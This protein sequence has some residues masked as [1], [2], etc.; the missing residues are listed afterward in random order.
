MENF[1]RDWQN[2]SDKNIKTVTKE[3]V[4]V[5]ISSMTGV[6][7][8]QLDDGESKRLLDMENI[9]HREV[10]G[11]DEAV[12]L[13]SGAV[14]RSRAGVSS[15]K[16][17]MGS[18]IFL[19]PTGV[20][21]TQLAKALAKFL[22]G[23]EDSLVRVDMS[24]Y[25][26]KQNASRLVGAPP[27]YIGYEEGGVLTEAVRQHPYSVVLL[28]EIEKAHPDIF[29]LLLQL[30]EEGELSDNLGHTVSFKNTVI[31]MTSNAGARQITTGSR[32]GFSHEEDGIM[33]YEDIKT[34]AMEELKKIMAP[35][36]LNRIDD[37]VVFNALNREQVSA[38][39]DIQMK[40]LDNRLAEQ[41]L[42]ISLK[43]EARD[44]MIE[45]GYDPSMGA[46]PMRRLIQRDIEDCLATLLL[47]GKRGS[48][49]K[50]VVDV[51]DGKLSVKFKKSRSS[52]EA[53]KEKL[54]LPSK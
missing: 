35:E 38:I 17:P 39:L 48:S 34:N 19:G 28:D 54:L 30:L 15:L 3:D 18:F 6:P 52:I 49:D 11:Q 31:I 12:S 27:G 47:S 26:E 51:C 22:F 9:I 16:R 50:I 40:E 7:L 23:S 21:K 14:R 29:N 53:P 8:E 20:G 25:M 10:I 42:S 2:S 5:I 33:A 1:T 13:I 32:M 41:G 44:F 43:K 36:L 4:G 46:R 37:V 24:D 45:H